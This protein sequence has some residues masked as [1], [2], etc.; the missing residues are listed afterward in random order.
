MFKEDGLGLLQIES[1]L[2][3][4]NLDIDSKKFSVI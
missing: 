1:S 3:K 2:I 4:K